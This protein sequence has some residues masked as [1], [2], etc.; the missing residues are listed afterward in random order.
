M[1]RVWRVAEAV[2]TGMI[3]VNAGLVPTQIAPFAGI[4]RPGSR[5]L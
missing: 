1:G 2:E 3:G 4:I 5:R